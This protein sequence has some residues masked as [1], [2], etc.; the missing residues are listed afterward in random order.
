MVAQRRTGTQSLDRAVRLLREIAAHAKSGVR[1]TDLIAAT[2]LS[3]GTVRR[4]LA[5]MIREELL[6]QDPQT[7]R[8]FLG[9][10]IFKLGTIAARHC[11]AFQPGGRDLSRVATRCVP[12]IPATRFRFR[13]FSAIDM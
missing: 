1:L 12:N 4:L 2:G 7:R 10:E 8:Y 13:G 3:K 9:H 11:G 6:E 5:A